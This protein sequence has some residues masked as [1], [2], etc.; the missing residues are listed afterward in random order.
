[1]RNGVPSQPVTDDHEV[2]KMAFR[3]L[4]ALKIAMKRLEFIFTGERRRPGNNPDS[5]ST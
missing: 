4:I 3:D 5:L 2:F 1:M